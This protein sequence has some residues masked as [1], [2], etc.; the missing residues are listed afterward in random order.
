MSATHPEQDLN[1]LVVVHVYRLDRISCRTELQTR[2]SF[3]A[4]SKAAPV[5]SICTNSIRQ[6]FPCYSALRFTTDRRSPIILNIRFCADQSRYPVKYPIQEKLK[7]S[8]QTFS[9]P[10]LPRQN[11][12]YRLNPGDKIFSIWIDLSTRCSNRF[13]RKTRFIRGV[14]LDLKGLMTRGIKVLSTTKRQGFSPTFPAMGTQEC[15]PRSS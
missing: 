8:L 12:L 1:S 11:R 7:G 14:A 15:S 6:L 4:K 13:S 10:H 9:F 5:L 2:I 3:P